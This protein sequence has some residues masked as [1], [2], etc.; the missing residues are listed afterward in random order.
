MTT[1]N[2]H[3]N[4]AG[5]SSLVS[6]TGERKVSRIDWA[7]HHKMLRA[8]MAQDFWGGRRTTRPLWPHQQAAISHSIAYLCADA[9]I[10]SESGV[11]EAALL[12]LPTGAGK[13]GIIA[14]LARC[15]PGIRSV[16][17]LT[18]RVALTEQ[19]LDD[20]ESR[21]WGNIGYPTESLES[22]FIERVLPHK[23]SM[24][25]KTREESKDRVVW[26]ST[27]QSLDI[28]RR[29]AAGEI[30]PTDTT[31][32]RPDAGS[33]A[34]T[35]Q[36]TAAEAR[37]FVKAL[38]T[39]DLVIVDEGH[40]EPAPSWSRGVRQLNRPT[41]LLSATPFRNDYKSFRVRGRFVYNLG[42]PE[43]LKRHIIRDVKFPR[44][45]EKDFEVDAGAETQ[46]ESDRGSDT[47]EPRK[48]TPAE[49]ATVGDF[50]A[51]VKED[52]P[53]I[54]EAAAKWT[55]TP[56]CILRAGSFE[57][58]EL[59]QSSLETDLGEPAL[60]IHDPKAMTPQRSSFIRFMR[61]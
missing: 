57:A 15:L 2:T 46:V 56:K 4:A 48:L 44:V 11:L 53:A 16:L 21:F 38:E 3:L 20:V 42:F 24:L 51:L 25:L 18:P 52:M 14:V 31:G 28:I 6:E 5:S 1:S 49:K 39:F 37:A 19:L 36:R 26:V 43:A 59:L 33:K 54:L 9:R 55:P 17:L 61:L 47:Q 35:H 60:M 58:L 10:T 34:A 50:V 29:E 32:E 22:T 12:K 7:Q 13:S 45:V 40:Y 23:V 8:V 41:V 30:K 27:H